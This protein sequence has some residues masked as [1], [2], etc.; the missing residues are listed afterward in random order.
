MFLGQFIGFQMDLLLEHF[1]RSSYIRSFGTSSKQTKSTIGRWF[2]ESARVFLL[3]EHLYEKNSSVI[4]K[5][6]C[7]QIVL[8]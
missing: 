5:R 3:P 8:L 2:T 7:N 4:K 6:L 1:C